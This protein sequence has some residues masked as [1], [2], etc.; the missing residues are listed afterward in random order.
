MHGVTRRARR[1]FF[2]VR[3]AA[4]F[5]L[6][7]LWSAPVWAQGCAMCRATA[8]ATP[9]EGQRAINRAILLMI[10]PPIGVVTLGTGLIVRYA[11]R[12]DRERERE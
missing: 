3:V 2:W 1:Q 12:R 4:V 9:K 6:L 11:R 7:A 8:K 10:V 5:L